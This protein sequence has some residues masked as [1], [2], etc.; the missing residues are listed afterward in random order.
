MLGYALLGLLAV[1]PR[2]GYE[3]KAAFEGLL[4]G[5]W[6]LNIGQVYTTLSRLERD[7]LVESE[8]VAQDAFPDRKV[9]SL[10]ELGEKE[11]DRWLGA[12]S[13]GAVRLKDEFVLKILVHAIVAGDP[14]PL[15]AEQR[16]R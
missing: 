2:H 8:V 16:G 15:V 11:L 3:L 9:Y 5:T 12:A 14:R 6:S 4:G 7:G 13:P 1:A 10:T